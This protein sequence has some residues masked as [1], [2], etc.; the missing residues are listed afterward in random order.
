MGLLGLPFAEA[1]GGLGGGPVDTLIVMQ[2]LGRALALEP[3]L[4][5]V[6][7]GGGLL[8]EAGFARQQRAELVPAIAAGELTLAFAHAEAQSRYDLADVATTARAEGGGWVLD[9]EKRFVLA[10]DSADRLIVSARS[11]GAHRDRD[12]IS[13]FLVDAN[14]DG[15]T[16]RGYRTQD[17]ARA[18]DIRFEPRARRPGRAARRRPARAAGHRARRRCGHRRAVRRGGRA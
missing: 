15:V 18:A 2:A 10:G 4:A 9:G 12:G 13:L 11:A 14:A 3:Y 16:R 17:H 1:D 6:V 5:T 8:R 7:L